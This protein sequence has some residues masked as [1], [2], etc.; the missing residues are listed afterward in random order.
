M[1]ELQLRRRHCFQSFGLLLLVITLVG[2]IG[3]VP[4]WNNMRLYDEQ[5]NGYTQ[6]LHRYRAMT[7]RGPALQAELDTVGQQL[8]LSEYYI[9]A[10]TSA[11]AAAE[12]QKKVKG[13]V[14]QAGGKLVSTQNIASTVQE[15]SDRI[16]VRVRMNG[17][18]DILA[19]VLHNLEG[20]RPLLFVENLSIRS[21]KRV[22][23]R[24]GNRTTEFSL[25]TT[26]DLVGF[27][28]GDAE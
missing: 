7:E 23:G 4:W 8:G 20:G 19:D 12:L 11:L 17:G 9:N 2:A 15:D 27:L 3:L 14:E 21:N 26:F 6:Q 16:A 28:R 22:R 13:V 25:D 18:V 10:T 5:S 24:R 1:T